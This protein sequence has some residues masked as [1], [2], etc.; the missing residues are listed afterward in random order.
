MKPLN[1]SLFGDELLVTVFAHLPSGRTLRF[2][3]EAKLMTAFYRSS[4]KDEYAPIF[5]NYP[6]DADGIV[7][8]C[9][10]LSDGFSSLQQAR[11]LGRKN[12]DLVEYIVG[13]E[14]RMRYDMFI[15]GKLSGLE[16]LVGKL[17]NE[18]NAMLVTA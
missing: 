12:P 4:T 2:E 11:I 1:N 7:P 14:L 13:D 17:A 8:H 5:I 10:E 3:D 18:V 15:K 6:F 16:A 9:Q